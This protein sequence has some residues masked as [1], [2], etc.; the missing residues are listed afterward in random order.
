MRTTTYTCDRCGSALDAA[1]AVVTVQAG[2]TPPAWPTDPET[3]RPALEL[4]ARCL[5]E[6]STW[7]RPG[8][9]RQAAR[10]PR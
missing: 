7:L 4:C 10:E 1:R 8:P 2:A 3:G 6:L 5:D 9:P